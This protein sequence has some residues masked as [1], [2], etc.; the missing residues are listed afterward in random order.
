MPNKNYSLPEDWTRYSKVGQQVP[1]TRFIPFKV[2]LSNEI[3]NKNSHIGSRNKFGPQDIVDSGLNIGLVIDLTNTDRYYDK[4]LFERNGI[5]HHKL[6]S[7]GHA[8]PNA[9]KVNEFNRIVDKFL[10]DNS[11]NGKLIGVHCTHGINR[12]GYMICRYMIQRQ[13]KDPKRAIAEFN[14]ARG[15]TLDR[16]TYLDDLQKASW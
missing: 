14:T 6:R 4:S 3:L 9:E 12:T 5:Q 15:N 7:A 11:D 1:K 16:E 8:I 13:G 10:S 2:P